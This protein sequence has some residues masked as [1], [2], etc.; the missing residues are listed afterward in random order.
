M[1]LTFF[2]GAGLINPKRFLPCMVLLDS[3]DFLDLSKPV[4]SVLRV[5]VFA[6]LITIMNAAC[7]V[8]RD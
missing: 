6:E 2:K 5:L 4:K 1:N 3:L 7:P 8:I